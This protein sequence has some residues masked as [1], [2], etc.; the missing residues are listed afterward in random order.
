M[1][2][3]R[4]KQ[5]TRAVFKFLRCSKDCIMQKV[6]FLAVNPSLRR[7]NNVSGMYVVQ[8]SLLLI[9]RQGLVDF[10][11][12]RHLLPIGR[13]IVQILHQRRRITTNSAPIVLGAIQ[14]S[15]QYTFINEQ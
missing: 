8:V 11:K 9:G 12:D 3:S 13:R 15:S 5:G 4:P 2:S 7:L 14:A 6:Y 10:F 1:V